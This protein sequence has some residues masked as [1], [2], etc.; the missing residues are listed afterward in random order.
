MQQTTHSSIRRRLL[1]SLI[2]TIFILWLIAAFFVYRAAYH[3]V[4]EIY[5]ATLAQQSRIL[6]TLMTHEV[7]EDTAVKDNL[8]K[9]VNELG[10]DVI[11]NSAFLRQL[12]DE[13]M[14][15]ES[16][17]DYLTLVPR[18]QVTGHRYEVK[19][20]FLIKGVNG[21]T[22]LR[23]N[24]PTSFNA[25]TEG[26]N[27]QVVDGKSWRMY[28]LK[29]PSG[30]FHVQVGEL[31]SVREETVSEIV[32]SSLW[33]IIVFL[34]VIGLLIWIMVGGGLKPLKVIAN[35][36]E[37]RDPNSLVPIST[38]EV[39]R[40]VVPMVESLN[41]LFLRVDSALENER[42]FTA[43]AAH[44]LRTPLAALKTLAQ[45]KS[46]IDEN[47]G[48]RSFLDQVIRGVDRATH[49]LEQ[50]LT[51]ARM[52][53]QS[54]DKSHTQEADLHGEAINVLASLGT[55]ALEKDIELSYEGIERPIIIPGYTP[56]IQILLR[57]LIDNAIRYTPEKGEVSVLLEEVEAGVRLEVAD[58]GP[59]IPEEKQQG[60]YQRFRRGEA[61]NTEGSGLGLSIVKRI[62]DLHHATIEMSNR[63]DKSGLRVSITFPRK[64]V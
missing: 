44:E 23:S 27:N 7:E 14:A 57:N 29:E 64:L 40:E 62:V 16:E 39:P 19:I 21:K 41:R 51:L 30:Q 18:E 36:V 33:P 50:L 2:S 31:K 34:P 45:A 47:N 35:K 26:Y 10:D 15:D 6:A 1:F 8:Q 61:T 13:Y 22:Y 11:E 63:K 42:R 54:V 52:D 56:G 37:R 9:L 49:L 38:Q 46:L 58:T 4:E 28:G 3:E 25:F 20:A 60:F 53:S 59:G 17:K 32:F 24:L 55:M 43:D 5:D 48:H 12:L